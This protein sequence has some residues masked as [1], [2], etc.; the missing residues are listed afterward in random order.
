MFGLFLRTLG[1]PVVLLLFGFGCYSMFLFWQQEMVAKELYSWVPVVTTDYEIRRIDK[2]E[3]PTKKGPTDVD[4]EEHRLWLEKLN[5]MQDAMEKSKYNEYTIEINYRYEY[6]GEVR[7][8]SFLSPF[9]EL[10]QQALE[11]QQLHRYLLRED[12]P[13]LTV[14][15]DPEQ[16]TRSSLVRGW[17]QGNRWGGLVIGGLLLPVSLAMLYFLVRPVHRVEELFE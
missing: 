7:A 2:P 15:V 3:W 12:H 4:K 17:A 16:P 10:N 6:A 14:Y 11:D 5:A 13:P 9:A 1:V 8:V